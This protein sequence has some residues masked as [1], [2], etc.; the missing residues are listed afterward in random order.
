[1]SSRSP[2]AP[3][4]RSIIA[5]R[6][7]P[8][9]AATP[10]PPAAGRRRHKAPS[11]SFSTPPQ[12]GLLRLHLGPEVGERE[13]DLVPSGLEGPL[14]ILEVEEHPD[15]GVYELLQRVG[16]LDL[17]AAEPALLA[18]HE[19]LERRAGLQRGHEPKE[20]RPLDELGAGDPIV[21]V[22]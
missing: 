17:L 21:D 20:P 6:P 8:V 2:S 14:P 5:P 1:M 11:R 16:R 9:A 10:T 12:G 3:L 15:A 19:D 7:P 13:H 4:K 22:D 18:H